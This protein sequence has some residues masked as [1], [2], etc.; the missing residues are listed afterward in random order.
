MR[1]V[2]MAEPHTPDRSFSVP[3]NE[4][5][6]DR[7]PLDHRGGENRHAHRA[8]ISITGGKLADALVALSD[9]A[10][11]DIIADPRLLVDQSTRG[12]TGD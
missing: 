8:T 7:A 5:T 6:L 4:L 1:A 10:G 9:A 12:V 2:A 3:P 11:V